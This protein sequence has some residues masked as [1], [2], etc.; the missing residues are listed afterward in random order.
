MLPRNL[1]NENIR[2]KVSTEQWN[3]IRYDCYRRANYKCEIC[4]ITRNENSTVIFHCHENWVFDYKKKWAKIDKLMCLCS[5]CHHCIHFGYS[6]SQRNIKYS[7][8]LVEHW[9]VVNFGIVKR[10]TMSKWILH[11][12]D[13][14]YNCDVKNAINW[15]VDLNWDKLVKIYVNN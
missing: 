8:E 14:C 6:I 13:E 9:A 3:L 10:E 7:L 11:Y 1:F 2:A 4:G 15:K 5:K 12:K